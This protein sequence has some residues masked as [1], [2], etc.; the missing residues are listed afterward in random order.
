M[1]QRMPQRMPQL[2]RAQEPESS[3]AFLRRRSL[4]KTG[5][6]GLAGLSGA[7]LSGAGVSSAPVLAQ[8]TSLLGFKAVA[9]S[10][11]DQLRVPPDYSAQVLLRWGDPVGAAAGS[12]GFKSDASNSAQEQ[13]LQAGMHHD[14]MHYFPIDGSSGHGLLALNH[15]YTDEALL[16]ANGGKDWGPEQMMKSLHA[17]GVS[18]VE[19]RRSADGWAVVRPSRFGRRITAATPC[20]ITGA[21]AGHRLMKTAQEPSGTSVLGTLMNCANGWTPWG[22]YLTC[23]ENF[24]VMFGSATPH[25]PTPE[26]QRYGIGRAS[27]PHFR[28]D[29]RFDLGRT[30]NE[31]NR[32]G[33]VVEIDPYDPLSVPVK[34]TAMGRFKHEAAVPHTGTDGRV[35]FYLSDD[36][37]FEY[38]YKF[39]TATAPKPGG[40]AAN[41]TMLDDG[42]LYVARFDESGS[43]VWLPLVHGSGP[44]TASNG[45]PDQAT[46]LIHARLAADLLGATKM[47]RPE[48]CAVNPDSHDIFVA[49]TN[50][51]ARGANG[52]PEGANAANP[53]AGNYFGHILRLREALDAAGATR[54]GWSF[55]VLAGDAALPQP[56]FKGNIKGDAFASPDNLHLDA[57]GVLWIQTDVS[58]GAIGK[59]PYNNL[60]NNQLLAADP[61]SGEVRRFMT[62]PRGAEVTGCVLTSDA[63]TLFVNIQHP[64]ESVPSTWPDGAR[65]RSATVVIRRNDGGVVG[66]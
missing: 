4:L 58:G 60:G 33:W 34:R 61:H 18:V 14:G 26:Q 40:A 37:G 41:R 63:K 49:C 52:A 29:P 23:E 11:A 19:V 9:A 66:T 20:A 27:Y 54:F 10:V 8:G 30:P 15:E 2:M 44:L 32:F 39:V 42:T 16:H 57:R 36:E 38:L 3:I 47:D 46:V 45:M 13:A 12:P 56:Q 59:A 22:T 21:A 53:R 6:G 62:A 43:G 25:Q 64:G 17:V 1:L 50:N 35:A 5:L 31:S 48:G 7:A 65:P 24:Q 51:A 55:F 28:L